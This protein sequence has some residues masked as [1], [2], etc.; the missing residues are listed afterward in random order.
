MWSSVEGHAD[1]ELDQEIRR[2]LANSDGTPIVCYEESD[3]TPLSGD[4]AKVLKLGT[5]D[6][7]ET[8]GD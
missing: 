8:G 3:Q 1:T 4:K 5:E 2:K 6:Y 7:T